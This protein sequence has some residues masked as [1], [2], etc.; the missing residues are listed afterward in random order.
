M[1]VTKLKAE[2][3]LQSQLALAT[4][5]QQQDRKI[6]NKSRTIQ[7]NDNHNRNFIT[8]TNDLLISTP[9]C[10]LPRAFVNSACFEVTR[11]MQVQDAMRTCLHMQAIF[12]N[13]L[14]APLGVSVSSGQFAHSQ[15]RV[16]LGMWK[17]AGC[18]ITTNNNTTIITT[19]DKPTAE[20]AFSTPGGFSW[21]HNARYYHTD[22]NPRQCHSSLLSA[23]ADRHMAADSEGRF[24]FRFWCVF[25][26][27]CVFCGRLF[28]VFCF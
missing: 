13:C 10:K 24:L 19:T 22:V 25:Y 12:A 21:L 17:R 3:W 15:W 2:R 18:V 28:F 8:N 14:S 11:A 7:N 20:L 16:L 4:A 23:G 27:V 1:Q 6:K 5:K 9:Q 26:P